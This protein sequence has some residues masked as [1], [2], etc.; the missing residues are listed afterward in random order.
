[1]APLTSDPGDQLSVDGPPA[2]A[3]SRV[4]Q[5]QIARLR[6]VKQCQAHLLHFASIGDLRR[7]EKVVPVSNNILRRVGIRRS[8]RA[9]TQAQTLNEKRHQLYYGVMNPNIHVPAY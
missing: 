6:H 3:A 4:L 1:M 9:Q 8:V 7:S 5:V 2:S